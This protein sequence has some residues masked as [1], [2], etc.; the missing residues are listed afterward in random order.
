MSKQIMVPHGNIKK[1]AKVMG[2]SREY[3]SRCLK[4]DIGAW[5]KLVIKVRHTALREFDGVE[6]GTK[7]RK[8]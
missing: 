1:L 4:G 8:G 6:L 2:I 5:T 3:A 7:L